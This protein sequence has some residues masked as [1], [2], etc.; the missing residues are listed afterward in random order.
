M[1]SKQIL[2]WRTRWTVRIDCLDFEKSKMG[3][4]HFGPSAYGSILANL[5][6]YRERR[7]PI[8]KFLVTPNNTLNFQS[9]QSLNSRSKPF[10]LLKMLKC[11]CRSNFTFFGIFLLFIKYLTKSLYS[12]RWIFVPILINSKK[13]QK[14]VKFDLQAHFNISNKLNG[15]DRLF[16]LWKLWKWRV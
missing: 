5:S 15:L 11:A 9:F 8:T 7:D 10:K 2:I 12:D 3:W 6:L 13:I 1:V 4:Q 14:N 16:G